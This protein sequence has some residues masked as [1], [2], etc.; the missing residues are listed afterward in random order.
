VTVASQRPKLLTSLVLGLILAGLMFFALDRLD[1][2]LRRIPTVLDIL[3]IPVLGWFSHLTPAS[4]EKHLEAMHSLRLSLVNWLEPGQKHIVVT[5]VDLG[6]GKSTVAVGLANSFA[7]AGLRVLLID[8]DTVSASLH[9][10][11]K[12]ISQTPGLTD[13]LATPTDHLWS[14]IPVT[15][16]KN[17][18]LIPAGSKVASSS[19]LSSGAVPKLIHAAEAQADIVI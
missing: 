9:E 13:F 7:Q 3:P 5:S 8:A 10:R 4:A 1:P 14:T 18:K 12:G 19:L 16:S 15:V 17:L 2:R 11:Y 6:D